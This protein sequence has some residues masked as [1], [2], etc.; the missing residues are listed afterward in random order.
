MCLCSAAATGLLGKQS[1]EI[2]AGQLS[3][4]R[5]AITGFLLML[6]KGTVTLHVQRGRALQSKLG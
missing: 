5:Y 4:V 1:L 6:L 3:A 2:R